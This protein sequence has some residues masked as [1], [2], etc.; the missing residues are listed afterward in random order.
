MRP[1]YV[2]SNIDINGIGNL[3]QA[4]AFVSFYWKRILDISSKVKEID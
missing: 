2:T 4:K 1:D 3:I